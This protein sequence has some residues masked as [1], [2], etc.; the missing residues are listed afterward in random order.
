MKTAQLH[1]KHT[2]LYSVYSHRNGFEFNPW[3]VKCDNNESLLCVIFS[4]KF[5]FVA[6]P[7]GFSLSFSLSLSALTVAY[8]LFCTHLRTKAD[9]H[10]ESGNQCYFNNTNNATRKAHEILHVCHWRR[11]NDT[12]RKG[13]PDSTH[14]PTRK[15][16]PIHIRKPFLRLF[17]LLNNAIILLWIVNKLILRNNCT[18]REKKLNR[19]INVNK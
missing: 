15:P 9:A 4:I 16:R 3:T 10:V 14:T 17:F 19:S 7:D 2:W 12:R 13:T 18:D 11:S 8:Y 1:H 5:A 6:V